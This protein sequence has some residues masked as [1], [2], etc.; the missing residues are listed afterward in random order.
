MHER[1]SKL[2]VLLVGDDDARRDLR[3][4]LGSFELVETCGVHRALWILRRAPVD[5]VVTE[6]LLQDGTGAA[7]LSRVQ[8]LGLSCVRVLI[9][10]RHLDW[11]G[12][13]HERFFLKTATLGEE[14]SSWL[15]EVAR[16]VARDGR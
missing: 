14:L 8:A 9:S 3:A 15:N 1:T 2:R 10:T 6:Q 7:L 4:S 13:A 12:A 11:D 16:Q 5:V